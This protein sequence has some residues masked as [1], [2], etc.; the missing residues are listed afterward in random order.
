MYVKFYMVC[1]KKVIIYN[2]YLNEAK[3]R[4]P[5]KEEN[6]LNRFEHSSFSQILKKNAETLEVS[7]IMM[8]KSDANTLK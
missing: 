6:V 1:L 5:H 2:K 3:I 8:R 7:S 4:T